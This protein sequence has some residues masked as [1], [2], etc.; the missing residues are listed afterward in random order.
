M[1]TNDSRL[2][3][4]MMPPLFSSAGRCWMSA[5][6]GTAKKPAQKPSSPKQNGGTDEA[7]V[8]GAERDA[9]ARHADGAE[10]D[11]AVLDLVAAENA[12]DHAADADANGEC[13]VEITGLGLADVQNIGTEDDDGGEQQ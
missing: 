6:T 13:G 11:E 10:R 9:G 12:G 5:F 3:A 7:D 2:A 8:H 1:P 4:A